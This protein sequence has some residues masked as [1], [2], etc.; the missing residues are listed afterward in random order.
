[1]CGVSHCTERNLEAL[2]D[3]IIEKSRD[4]RHT[5]PARLTSPLRSIENRVADLSIP[6][7]MRPTELV[8]MRDELFEYGNLLDD[9]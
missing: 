4:F 3:A 8:M 7:N 6:S 1:M 9:N 2:Q 5:A